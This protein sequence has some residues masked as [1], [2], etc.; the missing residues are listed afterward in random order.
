MIIKRIMYMLVHRW[1]VIHECHFMV[2]RWPVQPQ[3][4]YLHSIQEGKVP[5]YLFI[6]KAKV[7]QLLFSEFPLNAPLARSTSYPTWKGSWKRVCGC[8]T[9]ILHIVGENKIRLFTHGSQNSKTVPQ[10]LS[11]PCGH[12]SHL[13]NQTLV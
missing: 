3:A 7:S 5:K 6:S 1:L 12:T 10:T 2:I 13:H 9:S 11:L 8:P 4:S